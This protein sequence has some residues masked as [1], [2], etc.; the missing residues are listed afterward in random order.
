M[1][2][3]A[4]KFVIFVG[5]AAIGAVVS[6]LVTRKLVDETYRKAAD[7]EI[8]E[9]WQKSKKRIE[10]YKGRIKTLEEKVSQQ[11]LTIQA[12]ADQIRSYGGTPVEEKPAEEDETEDDPR[13]SLPR[14]NGKSAREREKEAYIGY[15]NRYRERAEAEFPREDDDDEEEDPEISEQIVSKSG[16]VV[17]SESDFATQCL[18]YGKEDLHFFMFDGKILSDDGDYLDNYAAFIGEKWHDLG[19]NAG[20]EVYVRNDYFRVDY[21]IIFTAGA[22]ENHINLTDIW[23]D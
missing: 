9:A 12:Q 10:E 23:D 5:G 15:A 20:D 14:S 21:R 11:N 4:S 16:P 8:Y 1:S 6:A 17:I 18:D 22:G 13:P 3:K 19:H 2:D 7:D